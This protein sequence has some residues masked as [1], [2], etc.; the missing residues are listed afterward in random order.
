A[1]AHCDIPCGIY[2]PHRA[3]MAAHTVIRMNQL[4][5]QLPKPA[6]EMQP[7]QR[8]ELMHNLARFTHAKEEHAEIVKHEVR[9]LWGDFFKPE[10]APQGLH[11]LVWKIMK[12]GSQAKVEANLAAAEQLLDAVNQLA[13]H[14]WAAKKVT[15]QRVTAPYPT[16]KETVY[17]KF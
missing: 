6:P 14:F 8:L 13:E 9:I 17:P 3:L 16:E 11:D 2:D 7:A 5:Q 12:L 4:I 15:T 10:Q 1:W